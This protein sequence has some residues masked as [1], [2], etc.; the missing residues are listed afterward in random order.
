MKT[1]T[2]AFE[3][4]E[5]RQLL[6][7]D[8]DFFAVGDVPKE[9]PA[10][11]VEWQ[12]QVGG[13][14]YEEARCL[15]ESPDGGYVAVGW[16]NSDG[17]GGE[18]VYA[19]KIDG[20]GNVEWQRTFGGA[21]LDRA[22][23]IDVVSTGGYVLAGRT[24]SDQFTAHD[25]SAYVVRIS[26]QGDLIWEKAFG[27]RRANG[28]RGVEETWDGGFIISGWTAYERHT[29]STNVYVVKTDAD[30]NI[31]WEKQY[32]RK[33]W[34]SAHE[35]R[36]TSDG[37]YVLAGIA[38][39]PELRRMSGYMMKLDA[40]GDIQWKRIVGTRW[41]RDELYTVEETPQGDFVFAGGSQ[42]SISGRVRMRTWI[43]KT[44]PDGQILWNRW[45]GGGL[46]YIW[47]STLTPD[48]GLAVV[49]KTSN[50]ANMALLKV[51]VDGRREWSMKFG[52]VDDGQQY[53][54][55]GRSVVATS[56]GG[57]VFVGF[58]GKEPGPKPTSKIQ[59]DWDR[60]FWFVKLEGG[61]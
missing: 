7:A 29:N 2:L 33:R 31:E 8:V 23:S 39:P 52:S 9:P 36:Q 26:E 48:G 45:Y 41:G 24:R 59:P 4:L 21:E 60:D 11:A 47:G 56:G 42:R 54:D 50:S 25:E 14:S 20:Q 15:V 12:T 40:S 5:A 17:A 32:R 28:A 43:V 44:D 49:G 3:C 27:H 53:F 61:I 58:L 51:D 46:G 22:Y 37:G 6:S 18:D 13:S 35:I 1:R 30:G 38:R 10:D 57:L 19:V 16:T 34:Q 55:G